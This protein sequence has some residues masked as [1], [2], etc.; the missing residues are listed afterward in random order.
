MRRSSTLIFGAFWLCVVGAMPCVAA[1]TAAA[2]TPPGQPAAGPG[3]SDYAF[4][5]ARATAYGEGLEAYWIIEPSERV[6]RAL[7][8]V[9]FVHGLGQIN[10]TVYRAWI[11]HLVRRGNVVIYPRYHLGGIVDPTT[12]TNA[13]A[14][15]IV[16]ALAKCDGKRHAAIDRSQLTMIGH[17]LGGTIVANLAA[18]PT[19]Y[20]LPVPRALM[21]LQPGDTRA[22]RGVGAFFPSIAQDHS[23]IA[24]GTLMLIVDVEGDYFVSAKAGQRLFD[25]AIAV[26]E[27]DKRRLLLQTDTHGRPVLVADHM[28]PMGW[29]DRQSSS[30]RVNV[31]DFAAWRWFDAMQATA[32]GDEAQRGLVFGEA[33]LEMGRW[34]DGTRVSPPIDQNAE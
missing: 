9:V 11:T 15:N 32:M 10:H 3:G 7:P 23:T 12:F 27:R 34:S 21:L 25:N 8:V 6:E 22:D 1:D 19:R 28:L 18:T 5:A 17:S 24:D 31:Y 29:T 14:K 33:A 2:A 20:R 26:D 16:E 13:A 4:K 30:G